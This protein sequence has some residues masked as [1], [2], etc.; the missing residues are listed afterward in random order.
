MRIHNVYGDLLLELSR[1]I[2]NKVLHGRPIDHFQFNIGDSSFQLDYEKGYKLPA[3]IINLENISPYSNK[4]YVF[5]HRSGNIHKIPVLY[6]YNKDIYLRVQEEE[7]NITVSFTIN[8]MNHMQALDIQH[9]LLSYLPIGKYMHFY[10]FTCFLEVDDFLINDYLFNVNNDEI[11]NLFLK[12]N[13]FTDSIDYSFSLRINP[14]LRFNNITVQLGED[15]NK[16]TFAVT[17]DVEYFMTVPVYLLHP[18][19]NPKLELELGD[20]FVPI[21]REN[22]QISVGDN[23]NYV[24]IQLSSTEPSDNFNLTLDEY[25]FVDEYDSNTFMFNQPIDFIGKDNEHVKGTLEGEVLGEIIDFDFETIIDNS[26]Y[27]GSGRSFEIYK[28]DSFTG[29]IEGYNIEGKLDKVKFIADARNQNNL[30]GWFSGSLKGEFIEKEIFL[31]LEPKYKYK[32]LTNIRALFKNPQYLLRSYERIFSK[33]IYRSLTDVNQT[34]TFMVSE[35]SDI[36]GITLRNKSTKEKLK[37]DLSQ[38]PIKLSQDGKFEL[39][40]SIQN[41]DNDNIHQEYYLNKFLFKTP[42]GVVFYDFLPEGNYRI[43]GNINLEDGEVEE[44]RFEDLDN[45]NIELDYVLDKFHFDV[46]NF[47]FKP[48]YGSPSTLERLHMDLS[49]TDGVMSTDVTNIEND[50]YGRFTKTFILD[51]LLHLVELEDSKNKD[52]QFSIGIK[53]LPHIDDISKLEWKLKLPNNKITFSEREDIILDKDLST[54][55]RLYFKLPREFYFKFCHNKINKANPA[56]LSV[57]QPK[58]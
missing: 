29:E 30:T 9:Q 36:I 10:E 44:L 56:F 40:F 58:N 31:Q 39:V 23:L 13:R 12:Q 54:V 7:F 21:K 24:R 4:P 33:N 35:G 57:G 32:N 17:M 18:P 34:K 28:E 25:L 6:D 49:W 38:T 27:S 26:I 11:K 47:K 46:V 53:G 14:L 50:E 5:Q 43:I 15:T 41:I 51:E 20:S 45:P 48:N 1:F 52:F 3:G 22:V 19:I 42:Y 2:N 55:E 37:V 16:N 8:C